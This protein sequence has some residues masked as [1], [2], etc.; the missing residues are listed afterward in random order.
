MLSDLENLVLKYIKDHQL[1]GVK[2]IA[3][4]LDISETNIASATSWLQSKGLVEI[5]E[6]I[7]AYYRLGDEGIK[8][9]EKK[10]PE[11]RILDYVIQ[12]SL[13]ICKIDELN[14]EIGKEAVNVGINW[15]LRFGA[16]IRSGELYLENMDGF[17]HQICKE[18]K[19]LELLRAKGE[20]PALAPEFK[21]F[22][23]YVK[24][25]KERKIIIVRST[26]KK[27]LKLTEKGLGKE[28]IGGSK[29]SISQLS[30]SS[31]KNWKNLEF[32]R[33]GIDD[34][35]S[36][37]SYGRS[38]FLVSMIQEIRERLFSFG[39]EEMEGD[40]IE[41]SFWDMDALFIPQL[42]SAR[43]LQDTFYLA[44]TLNEIDAPEGYIEKIRE[45][46]ERSWHSRWNIEIAKNLLLR[47]HTTV[48]S[49][50]YLYNHHDHGKSAF[51][52]F[53]VG[54]IFR[55]ESMD[56]KHLME[57][58]QIDCIISERRANLAMLIGFLKEF[59]S[60]LGL[61][62]VR[63]KPSYYPYTEPSLD[64]EVYWNGEWLELGGAGIFREEVTAP[65]GIENPVLA[66]GLGLERFAIL[67]HGI[68]DIREIYNNEL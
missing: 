53:T 11:R 10:L 54:K 41:S 37:V 59:Y 65:S 16:K 45:V 14:K 29:P 15:L 51:K 6:Y 49:I 66:C 27:E 25:F 38:N 9:M 56:S 57:L 8:W 24:I 42:H 4:E 30:S 36:K 62:K 21:E 33:Y 39:F 43:E 20:L 40:W 34:P 13:S 61:D 32:R 1:C 26:L 7:G 35:V 47:T 60:S 22:S 55:R 31:I 44:D 48:C 18:E 52:A 63:V 12:N 46:H 58:Y 3:K 19:L 67:R 28:I 23:K 5:R 50:K 68:R 17:L 64:V 2:D